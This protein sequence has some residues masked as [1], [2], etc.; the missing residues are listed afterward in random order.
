MPA[1]GALARAAGSVSYTIPL[2]CTPKSSTRR[3]STG[4]LHPRSGVFWQFSSWGLYIPLRQAMASFRSGVVSTQSRA[5]PRAML[6][7]DTIASRT[8]AVLTDL[9][10]L[11][12]TCGRPEHA[13][14]N[15]RSKTADAYDV[16]V[17]VTPIDPSRV[18]SSPA[19]TLTSTAEDPRI[20]DGI[21]TAPR[22]GIPGQL[23]TSCDT[24]DRPACA[25]FAHLPHARV[26]ISRPQCSCLD[27]ISLGSLP[28]RGELPAHPRKRQ[29]KGMRRRE[30]ENTH[31][32]FDPDVKRALVE[33]TH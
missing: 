9:M 8:R 4:A 7:I 29:L 19:A 14:D 27:P 25:F 11:S 22:T 33:G 23:L 10:R 20:P 32:R 12:L 24:D 6:G 31:D 17:R 13:G 1:T 5:C 18:T 21:A 28:M 3:P 15:G 30:S 16:P 26:P 2:H